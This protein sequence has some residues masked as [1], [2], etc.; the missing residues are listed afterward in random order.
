[1]IT[2]ADYFADPTAFLIDAQDCGRDTFVGMNMTLHD[3]SC[4]Q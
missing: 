4:L 1:M 3:E 2:G